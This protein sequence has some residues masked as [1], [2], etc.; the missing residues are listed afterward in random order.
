MPGC[1]VSAT[2]AN[3]SS[4]EK[5]RLRATP[6]ITST[7]ENVSDIGTCLGLFLG[8]LGYRPCPVKTGC[9]PRIISTDRPSVR[10]RALRLDDTALRGA[11]GR[12]SDASFLRA[13]LP[14]SGPRPAW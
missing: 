5:R 12:R 6:V 2:T 11:V 9:T 7:F 3:F 1:I 10:Y 4:V 14:R 8:P 13:D